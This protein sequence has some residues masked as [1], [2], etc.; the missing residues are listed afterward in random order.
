MATPSWGRKNLEFGGSLH[1]KEG[2]MNGGTEGQHFYL[3]LLGR[4]CVSYFIKQ[5]SQAG[6]MAQFVK[7]H[8]ARV[9]TE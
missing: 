9:K 8:R 3:W 2:R 6:E 4:Q 5:H 7:S 1:R